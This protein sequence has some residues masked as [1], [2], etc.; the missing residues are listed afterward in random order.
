[1]RQ[2][3]QLGLSIRVVELNRGA[4]NRRDTHVG[5]TTA[6][7]A[8]AEPREAA[9]S[10]WLGHHVA[11]WVAVVMGDTAAPCSNTDE[12]LATVPIPAVADAALAH[13]Q[14]KRNKIIESMYF[15]AYHW[16]D[17]KLTYRQ[18]PHASLQ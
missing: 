7:T 11:E 6:S 13:L 4:A 1:M 14:I 8:A 3:D 17:E 10:A 12:G 5:V 2:V 18:T 16:D 9:A 15:M